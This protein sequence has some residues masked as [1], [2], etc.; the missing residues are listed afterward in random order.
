M[1]EA[2][3]ISMVLE[4]L[5]ELKIEMKEMR[6]EMQTMREEQAILKVKMSWGSGLISTVTSVIIAFV[7]S[8]FRAHIK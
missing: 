7:V 4:E 5:K 8:M 6:K 1:S 2:Q 3:V